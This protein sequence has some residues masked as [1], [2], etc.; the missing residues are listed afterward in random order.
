M[1]EV[2]AVTE[3][4]LSGFFHHFNCGRDLVGYGFFAQDVAAC[5]QRLQ[6]RLVMI[7]AIFKAGCGYADDIGSE[8]AQHGLNIV[9]G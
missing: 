7:G 1:V 3:A 5:R 2:D 9:K 8:C 4:Q 6:G